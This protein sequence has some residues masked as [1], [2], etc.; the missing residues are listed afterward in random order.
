MNPFSELLNVII[1]RECH[2]CKTKLLK[3]EEFICMDCIHKLPLT[4]FDK[5]WQNTSGPNSDLNPMEQRFAGQL[6]MDRACA[7]FFYTRDSALASLIHDFKYRG[8]SRLARHLAQIGAS[9]L[10]HSD[11]FHDTDLLLP[12]PLHWRKHFKRGYNQSRMIAEGVSMVTDIPVGDQLRARKAHRTQTALTTEQRISNTKDIF[13]VQHPET[14]AGK[15]V[16]IVDDICTTGATILSAGEVLARTV[17]D[18]RLKIFT[19]G[20]V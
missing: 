17:P 7:P 2:I 19:L 4:G 5:Y 18:I 10:L 16:M 12:I 9:S 14:L 1:P 20:V 13:C 6:P 11:F 15:T 3:N 8:F